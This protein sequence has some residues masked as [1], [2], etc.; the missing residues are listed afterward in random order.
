MSE[1]ERA[2]GM[3]VLMDQVKIYCFPESG[4]A[5]LATYTVVDAG[6]CLADTDYCDEA[7]TEDFGKDADDS[8]NLKSGVGL[9]LMLADIPLS[10][11]IIHTAFWKLKVVWQPA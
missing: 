2:A 9:L 3:F 8:I 4:V 11:T 1:C 6:Y 10:P 5:L 7:I